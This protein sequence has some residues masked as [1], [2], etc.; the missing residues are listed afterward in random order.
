MRR[1]K[2][3]SKILACPDNLLTGCDGKFI[4]CSGAIWF[5]IHKSFID[6]SSVCSLSS[7][8]INRAPRIQEITVAC[9]T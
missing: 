1:P 5:V 8:E 4:H 9:K 2:R 3:L 7:K 6:H